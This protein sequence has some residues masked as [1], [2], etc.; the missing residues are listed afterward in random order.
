MNPILKRTILPGLMA[1]SLAGGTLVPAQPAS[2]DILKDIGIGAGAG[3]VSGAVRGRGSV[4]NNAIKG[5]AAG[6]AVNAVHGTR[7]QARNR[8]VGNLGQDMGVGAAASTVTG[9]ILHGTKD[10]LGDA[11]DGAAA[12]AAINGIRNGQRNR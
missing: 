10:T 5:A 4:V 3:V 2:A 9:I 12:G 7:R 1:A 11:V 6:A 8:R